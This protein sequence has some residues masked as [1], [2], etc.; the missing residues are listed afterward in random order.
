MKINDFVTSSVAATNRMKAVRSQGSAAE[1]AIQV[2]LGSM[3]LIY[4]VQE[5]LLPNIQRRADIA[6]RNERVAVFVDG[7]FWHGCP[8]HGTQAKANA[9]FWREKIERNK[10]RDAHTNRCLAEAGWTVVRVWEHEDPIDAALRIQ[11]ILY[12]RIGSISNQ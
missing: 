6:F 5:Q 10:V 3:G 7:C 8:L 2:E 4:S 1:L 11:A 9:D 12:G